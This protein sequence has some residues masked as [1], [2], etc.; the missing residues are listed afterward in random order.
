MKWTHIILINI[1]AQTFF[2]NCL[3]KHFNRRVDT[4]NSVN[5][6]IEAQQNNIRIFDLSL[7]LRGK[8]EEQRKELLKDEYKELKR[9]EDKLKNVLIREKQEIENK[10]LEEKTE[11]ERKENREKLFYGKS[12][13]YAKVNK[14]VEELLKNSDLNKQTKKKH[15][16]L[17]C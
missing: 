14:F 12:I 17:F 13:D 6:E 5:K 15:H 16:N 10:R 11:R 1:I 3:G 9:L 7:K 8:F 4:V 2:A